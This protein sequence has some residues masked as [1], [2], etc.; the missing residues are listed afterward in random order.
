MCDR[1]V[2]MSRKSVVIGFIRP[3]SEVAVHIIS[4][5]G[6]I[7]QTGPDLSKNNPSDRLKLIQCP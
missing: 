1:N 2:A 4:G 3:R 7:M 6:S 5:S